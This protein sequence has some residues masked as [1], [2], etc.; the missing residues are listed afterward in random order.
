MQELP[1]I[2]KDTAAGISPVSLKDAFFNERRTIFLYGQIN[3]ES[4]QSVLME[5][6]YLDEMSH[7]DITILIHSPGGSASDGLILYDAI[8]RAQSKIITVCTG[9]AASMAS[10]LFVSG[11]HRI[12]YPH[13]EILIHDPLIPETG[14]SALSLS[15]TT[16]RLLTLREEMAKIYES[17]TGLSKK[18]ILAMTEKETIMNAEEAVQLHFADEILQ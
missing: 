8:Q 16:D 10:I 6:E 11:D 18:K 13:G 14:G 4:A 5:L 2:L 1:Y 17:H 9:L 3:Q 15:R 7:D 12:I